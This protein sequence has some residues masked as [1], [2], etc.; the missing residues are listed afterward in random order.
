MTKYL[1]AG[2]SFSCIP[3][4]ATRNSD[5]PMS[6]NRIVHTGPNN[7]LGATNDGLSNVVY[8]PPIAGRVNHDPMT[9]A[10]S[11]IAKH[12]INVKILFFWNQTKKDFR[13]VVF[14]V[15]VTITFLIL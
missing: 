2:W 13:V 10:N 11:G 7:R 9:P 14:F 3:R 5:I 15:G 1:I 12:I 8:R 4:F 6:T